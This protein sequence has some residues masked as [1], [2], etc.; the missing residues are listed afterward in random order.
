MGSGMACFGEGVYTLHNLMCKNTKTSFV[1]IFWFSFSPLEENTWVGPSSKKDHVYLLSHLPA[2]PVTCEQ[3]RV[4]DLR[5]LFD[6]RGE[7]FNALYSM[8]RVKFRLPWTHKSVGL[9]FQKL[10]FRNGTT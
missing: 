9:A 4:A 6:F 1:W 5:L 3:R 2:N 10:W 8:E 7:D